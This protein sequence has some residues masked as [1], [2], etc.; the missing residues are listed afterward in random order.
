MV[1][2]VDV[3]AKDGTVTEVIVDA[4]NGRVLAQQAD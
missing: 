2:E 1:Y 4:G 3:T